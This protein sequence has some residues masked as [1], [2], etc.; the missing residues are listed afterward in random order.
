MYNHRSRASEGRHV[1]TYIYRT[2]VHLQWC[3]PKC[4]IGSYGCTRLGK[5]DVFAT[6]CGYIWLGKADANAPNPKTTFRT[7]SLLMHIYCIYIN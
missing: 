4:D 3:Y 7:T 1:Q 2:L 5:A 6:D